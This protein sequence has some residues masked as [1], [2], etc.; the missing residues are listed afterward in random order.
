MNKIV[1]AEIKIER[2][3]VGKYRVLQN[4]KEIGKINK[5]D[6]V[7]YSFRKDGSKMEGARVGRFSAV[8]RFI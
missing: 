4:N 3:I 7:W 2:I 5:C 1:K 8:A 6:G